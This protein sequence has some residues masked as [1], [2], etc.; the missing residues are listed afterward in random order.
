MRSQLP[1]LKVLHLDR[2]AAGY[3]WAN[4]YTGG[5]GGYIPNIIFSPS[6]QNF[7]YARTDIGGAYRWNPSTNLWD[8]LMDWV[9]WAN[10]NMLGVESFATDSVNPNNLYVMAGLYTNSFTSQNGTLLISHDQGSTFTQVPMP[11]KVGGNMPA[12]NMGHVWQSI[13]TL[14]AFCSS[15]PEAETASGRAR[16]PELRQARSPTSPNPRH[17]YRCAR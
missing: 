12:R 13:P 5:G 10:W 3:T 2:T 15:Q 1:Y 4:V 6:Q 17:V 14:T 11:F 16:I 8:P 9:S 7:I